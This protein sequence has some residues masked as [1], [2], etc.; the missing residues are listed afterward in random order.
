MIYLNLENLLFLKLFNA[1]R[2]TMSE[3]IETKNEVN[4]FVQSEIPGY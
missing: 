2:N 4:Y 1:F 3:I